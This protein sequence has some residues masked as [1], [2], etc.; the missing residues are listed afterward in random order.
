MDFLEITK[1]QYVGDHKIHLWFNNNVDKVVDFSDKLKGAA[2]EPLRDLTF[3]KNL[4]LSGITV[5][6]LRQNTCSTVNRHLRDV[7]SEKAQSVAL[8]I[9][10]K[11][12]L[13]LVIWLF[14]M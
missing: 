7:K 6:I 9:E 5:L 2:F 10:I 13:T 12:L 1:A 11:R 14:E 3:F 4:Q 8:H